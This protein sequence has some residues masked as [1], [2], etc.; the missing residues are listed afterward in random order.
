M[1]KILLYTIAAATILALGSC[2]AKQSA[3]KAA[4]EQAK[5]R[6]MTSPVVEEEKEEVSITPVSKPKT[7]ANQTTRTERINAYQGEDA[8][9][10]RK[11]SVVV[12]SF[13]NKTNAYSLKERLAND[14][15]KPVLGENEQGMLRVII[16]SFD[17]RAEAAESRDAVKAKYA[18]NFQ[19]AWLLERQN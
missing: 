14:G 15:Y 5:D 16:T 18:P 11:F 7:S 2:K 8:S 1:N 3:Y 13:Q 9:G 17:S 6:E 19:D 10:L 4:Y 12:G